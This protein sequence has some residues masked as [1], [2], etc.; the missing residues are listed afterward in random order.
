MTG[1]GGVAA[2]GGVVGAGAGGVITPFEVE[3]ARASRTRGSAPTLVPVPEGAGARVQAQVLV[4][5]PDIDA[6]TGKTLLYRREIHKAGDTEVVY[7]EQI[8]ITRREGVQVVGL[9]D[10]AGLPVVLYT[11]LKPNIRL[12]LASKTLPVVKARELAR[13]AIASVTAETYAAGKDGIRYLANAIVNGIETPLTQHYCAAIL[14]LAEEAS[15][16]EAARA[17]VARQR[18]II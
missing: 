17:W 15:D 9:P 4:L 1:A 18:G 2:G 16:L 13:L 12:V 6:E 14:A 11:Y 3:F 10:F 5:R 7:D 8:Q